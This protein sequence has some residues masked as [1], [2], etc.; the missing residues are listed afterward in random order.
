MNLST[1]SRSLSLSTTTSDARD[2][3]ALHAASRRSEATRQVGVPGT[4]RLNAISVR[5]GGLFSHQHQARPPTAGDQRLTDFAPRDR[6]RHLRYRRS[7][8]A[9]FVGVRQIG[10][11]RLWLGECDVPPLCGPPERV[12]RHQQPQDGF[13]CRHVQVPHARGL[14]GS[15]LQSW[16]LAV[17]RRDPR[18]QGLNPI[19]IIGRAAPAA[20]SPPAIWQLATIRLQ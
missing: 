4:T 20:R 19:G 11:A 8:G 15:E 17:L 18:G 3:W 2:A 14:F 5:N 16:L 10:L 9:L 1:W 6:N 13:T 7:A 12:L